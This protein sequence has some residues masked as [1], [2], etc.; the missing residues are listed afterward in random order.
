MTKKNVSLMTWMAIERDPNLFDNVLRVAQELYEVKRV[1]YLYTNGEKTMTEILKQNLRFMEHKYSP[2][3]EAIPVEI[4]NPSSLQEVYEKTQDTLKPRLE[5]MGDLIICTTAGTPAMYAAWFLLS[6]AGFFQKGTELFSAQR[7]LKKGKEPFQNKKIEK[8]PTQKLQKIDFKIN[9]WLSQLKKI[10]KHIEKQLDSTKLKHPYNEPKSDKGKNVHDAILRYAKI[11]GAPLLIY[12]ERGV[13]KSTAVQEWIRN[14]KAVIKGKS[15]L[16]IVHINC[17]SLDPNLAEA[18]IFGY[19]P[20]AF[21]GAQKD[22]AEGLIEKAQNG[23]LFLDEVQDLK[24]DVQRKL[25]QVFNDHRYTKVGDTSNN[26][27]EI[28]FDLICATNKSE[29]ELKQM[30]DLDFYDRICVYKVTFPPLRERR[31]DIPDLWRD[32]WRDVCLTTNHNDFLDEGFISDD[33]NHYFS[34][35]SL[36]GN[37]RSL[38]KIAFLKIAWIN[39]KTDKEILD[40]IKDDELEAETEAISQDSFFSKYESLTWKDADAQFRKDLAQWSEQKYGSLS[41]VE[42]KLGWKIRNLQNALREKDD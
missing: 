39:E 25:L 5:S 31:E 27:I 11:S 14:L 6:A 15:E 19:V 29:K 23:I 40:M 16:P 21:T 12:G 20:G 10:E 32:T 13:G 42:N 8:E 1:Y 18:R 3:L 2:L 24:K 34:T 7:D 33:L 37:I 35:A 17:S 30:L 22:G 36:Y 41:N 4:N 28:K 26:E 9:T 38:R